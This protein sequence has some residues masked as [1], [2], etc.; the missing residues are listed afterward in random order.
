MGPLGA[1]IGA[2]LIVV[3][4]IACVNVAMLLVARAAARRREVGI[5]IAMGASR[6]ALIRQLAIESLLL[7][8]L[9]GAGATYIAH[10]TSEVLSRIYLPVPMPIA[11]VYALDWRVVG[12]AFAMS[13]ATTF[14]FGIGPARETLRIDVVSAVKSGDHAGDTG[15]ARRNFQHIVAQV[16]A[17]AA[18][19]AM[20]ALMVRS[21]HRPLDLGLE[22]DGVITAPARLPAGLTPERQAAMVESIL[23]RLDAVSGVTSATALRHIPQTFNQGEHLPVNLFPAEREVAEPDGAR[24]LVYD[25]L[26][27]RGHFRA[28]GIPLLEGRD[29][30]AR[31]DLVAPQTAIV[32]EAYRERFWPGESALGKILTDGAGQ[33]LTVVGLA[34]DSKYRARDEELAPFVYRPLSQ[35]PFDAPT[36]LVKSTLPQAEVA[37]HIREQIAV[38]DPTSPSTMCRLSTTV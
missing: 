25:N 14:L 4:W 19:L 9:A 35:L 22:V 26:V 29:F 18:L 28:L 10:V 8:T 7:A 32:N 3:L 21:I 37:T 1:L 31:D 24:P 17:S 30:E 23:E 20:A 2:I 5:R 36:F 11:A 33:R 34:P 27:T 15:R 12:F 16:A 38:V 6:A 13:L